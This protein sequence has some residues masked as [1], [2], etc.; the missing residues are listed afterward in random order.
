MRTDDPRAGWSRFKHFYFAPLRLLARMIRVFDGNRRRLAELTGRGGVAT[1]LKA[2]SLITLI[3]WLAIFVLADEHQRSALSETLR[4][5][6]ARTF[7]PP[8][9]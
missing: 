9:D 5:Y 2:L 8:G 6:W 1:A 7:G 3:A 4:D